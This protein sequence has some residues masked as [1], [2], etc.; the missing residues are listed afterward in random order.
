MGSMKADT[1]QYQQMASQTQDLAQGTRR[2]I[3]EARVDELDR[4]ISD[5]RD[6][7]EELER[8]YDKL[9]ERRKAVVLG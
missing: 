2:K 5:M 1:D 8:E 9:V 3:D 4:Q 7:N 6:Q